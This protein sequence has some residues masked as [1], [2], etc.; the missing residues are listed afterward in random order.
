MGVVVPRYGHSAVDR[1]RLKRR[2]R[3]LV[4]LH[5]LPLGVP[6]DVVI[7]AQRL[8][9]RLEFAQLQGQM[10]LV[11]SKLQRGWEAGGGMTPESKGYDSPPPS[12]GEV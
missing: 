7:W 3:E 5:M 11:V 6:A 10:E 4:R 1:N 8:A 12:P 2:L 9:Y